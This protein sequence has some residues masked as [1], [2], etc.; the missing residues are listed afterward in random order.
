MAKLR[1]AD[2]SVDRM[3]PLVTTARVHRTIQRSN[4]A[5][6]DPAELMENEDC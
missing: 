3:W 2:L 5:W 6:G 4:S 1:F